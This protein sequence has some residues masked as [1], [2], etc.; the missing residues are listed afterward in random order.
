M[1]KFINLIIGAIIGGIAL[2]T[3]ISMY[4]SYNNKEISLHNQYDAQVKVVEGV[5]D[6][7]WKVISQ[8]AQVS[9]EYAESFDS[10]YTHIISGRYDKG[11]G[12]LMKWIKESN[13][14]FDSSLYKEL[15]QSIE[16]LRSEFLTSQKSAIDIAREHNTLCEQFPGCWF[17]RNNTKIDYVVISSANTKTV[18]ETRMDDEVELFK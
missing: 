14:Q 15:S 17:I 13:P 10:I 8:K 6:K 18:M 16:V 5:H 4:F 9:Q 11:D 3:V 1:T 12:T 2:I 7:M